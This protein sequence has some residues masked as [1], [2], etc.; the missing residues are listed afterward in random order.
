MEMLEGFVTAYTI[1]QNVSFSKDDIDALK[2]LMSAELDNDFINDLKTDP[3]RREQMQ[4][5]FKKHKSKPHKTSE[6]LTLNVKDMLPDLSEALKKQ[7][8]KKIESEVKPQ[9]VYYS[10][11]YDVS[12]LKVNNN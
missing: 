11:G 3:I 5:E 10:E 4:E 2:K 8:G 7:G 9:V 6:L 12:T 1:T